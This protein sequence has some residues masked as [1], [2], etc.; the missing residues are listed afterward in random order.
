MADG[1]G[2]HDAV[3]SAAWFAPAVALISSVM[4]ALILFA[5]QRLVG[6]AAWQ[7]AITAGNRDLID[8][9]QEERRDMRAERSAERL[10]WEGE[11]AQMRGEI[12]NL[13]QAFESLKSYL[14]REGINVPEG[15]FHP[16]SEMTVIEGRKAREQ[17]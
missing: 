6:K 9:L 3:T 1:G 2:H 17:P 13:T 11:R 7:T 8:Q 4:T 10:S 12:I 5:A 15:V 14:R 16:A